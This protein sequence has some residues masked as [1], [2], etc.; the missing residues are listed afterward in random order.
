MKK[1][2]KITLLAP[3]KINVC[4]G[5]TGKRADGYHDIDSVMQTVSL[6]DKVTVTLAENE[7]GKEIT[8]SCPG[9]GEL[10]GEKNIAYR[11]A[12]AFFEHTK[13]ESFEVS[14]EIEKVIPMEAGLGGG[15]SD[16]AATL[17]ALNALTEA[18]LDEAE[19]CAIGAKIGADV[20]FLVRKGTAIVQ[21][22]GEIITPCRDLPEAHVLIAYPKN[23]KV[24][25]GKAYAAID[26]LG[27][28]SSHADFEKMLYAI[29]KGDLAAISSAGY[30]IFESVLPESSAVFRLKAE[31]MARGALM[32]LMSGSGSAVFG[33]FTDAERA[34]AA[35]KALAGEAKTFVAS[36]CRKSDRAQLS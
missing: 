23:E 7:E 4:L 12:K 31:M 5:V 15:S 29:E 32:S 25:T 28:F 20:P 3:A 11:A 13:A 22:I 2:K 16:A 36:L 19:L 24:S 30:N 14:I 18:K 34:S 17:I 27:E 8:V 1:E 6:C 33:F 35:A 26:A 9:H 10:D 21:G